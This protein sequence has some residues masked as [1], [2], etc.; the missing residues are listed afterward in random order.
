MSEQIRSA[1]LLVK[2]ALSSPQTMDALREKPEETLKELA[3]E[4]TSDLPRVLPPNG[5]TS[6][7]LWLIIVGSFAIV[8]LGSA[9]TLVFS[10]TTKAE[11]NATYITNSETVVMLFT[12][13]VAFLAGLLS[14]SPINK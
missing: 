1:D 5:S 7:V 14:P 11:A 12:T 13:A 8:M 3:K 10:I 2:S 9:F 4:A 6:N